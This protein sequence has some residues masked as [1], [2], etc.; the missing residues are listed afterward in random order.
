VR[1]LSERRVRVFAGVLR[2]GAGLLRATGERGGRRRL[3][4]GKT[5]EVEERKRFFFEKKNQ[6]TFLLWAAGRLIQRGLKEQKF[7]A[8]LCAAMTEG[9]EV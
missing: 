4:L 5:L 2:A 1:V 3:G 7:F 6:K 8:E 9:S